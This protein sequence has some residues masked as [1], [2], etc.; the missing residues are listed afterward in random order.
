MR[1]EKLW[2]AEPGKHK[3][4]FGVIHPCMNVLENE[5]GYFRRIVVTVVGSYQKRDAHMISAA[6]AMFNALRALV[7][8]LGDGPITEDARAAI[9]QAKGKKK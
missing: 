9:E 5:P 8:K 1:R 7:A 3:N 4:K 2:I 6:P